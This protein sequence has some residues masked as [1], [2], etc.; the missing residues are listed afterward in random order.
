M[1]LTGSRVV[2]ALLITSILL[3]HLLWS[4]YHYYDGG[5]ISHLQASKHSKN[6]TAK[7]SISSFPP[8]PPIPIASFPQLRPIQEWLIPIQQNTSTQSVTVSSKPSPTQPYLLPLYPLLNPKFTLP[9]DVSQ[10][11]SRWK[12]GW[13][14]KLSSQNTILPR[15]LSL[16]MI[17]I[18][19]KK[20]E[21]LG[22]VTKKIFSSFIIFLPGVPMEADPHDVKPVET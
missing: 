11:S 20:T 5:H 13:E 21:Q 22:Q 10:P 3:I 7:I 16:A 8:P 2:V 17:A 14:Y 19:T 9:Q 4:L 15:H 12:V 1:R 18:N 6:A